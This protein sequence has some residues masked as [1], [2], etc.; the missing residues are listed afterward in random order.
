MLVT[1]K[2]SFYE[3]S[4]TF[5]MF[6]LT[7]FLD[8]QITDNKNIIILKGFNTSYTFKKV[9]DGKTCNNS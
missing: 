6:M 1:D 5:K 2:S 8:F 3:N 9:Y 7:T 4:R